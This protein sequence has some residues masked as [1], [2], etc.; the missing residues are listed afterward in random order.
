MG[1]ARA[2]TSNDQNETLASVVFLD[3]IAAFDSV[4]HAFLD[5]ALK[6]AGA[7]DK[8]RSILRAIYS[9][10]NAVVRAKD[11]GGTTAFSDPLNVDRGVVQGDIVSPYCFIIE[12][13]LIMLRHD[14]HPD[15]GNSPSRLV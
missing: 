1:Q 10:A 14:D 9:K 13:Q 11:K 2:S 5:E 6:Y 12:L 4:D 15:H 3:Y 8:T 7:S